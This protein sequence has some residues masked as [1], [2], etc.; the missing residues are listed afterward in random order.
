MDLRKPY[1]LRFIIMA[2]PRSGDEFE[3]RNSGKRRNQV[4]Q[5]HSK[6]TC[7]FFVMLATIFAQTKSNIL[8]SFTE[9]SGRWFICHRDNH[10]NWYGI[11]HKGGTTD[12][13]VDLTAD[14]K[15]TRSRIV[16]TDAMVNMEGENFWYNVG[17]GI[18]ALLAL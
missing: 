5:L 3:K 6:I 2:N 10:F 18:G 8:S 7:I 15:C 9:K 17:Y 12:L 14:G 11:I 4:N 16:R 1:H 13:E